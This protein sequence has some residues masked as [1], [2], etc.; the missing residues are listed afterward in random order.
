MAAHDD[1]GWDQRGI[2][3]GSGR[4]RDG[5]RVGSARYHD[6]IVKRLGV[7]EM[8]IASRTP[9]IVVKRSREGR[10]RCNCSHVPKHCLKLAKTSERYMSSDCRES[11]DGDAGGCFWKRWLQMY[12]SLKAI[13]TIT[14]VR[15][16][17]TQ[18]KELINQRWNSLHS[19]RRPGKRGR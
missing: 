4:D 12:W 13:F 8:S 14:Y 11:R 17:R 2:R 9:V 3:E 15:G 18:D 7:G 1:S 5:I 6:R 10:G 16:D 19:R